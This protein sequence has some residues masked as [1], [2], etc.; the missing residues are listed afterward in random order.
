MFFLTAF[1]CA[2]LFH[3]TAKWTHRHLKKW[4]EK[5]DNVYLKRILLVLAKEKITLTVLYLVFAFILIF[6]VRDIGPALTSDLLGLLQGLS[7]KFSVDL[8][9][10]DLQNTLSQWQSLSY[11]FGDF[12]NVISPDTDTNTLLSQLFH[13]GSIFFQ[14]I[15]AYIIS[16]IWLLEYEKVQGYFAQLKEGPFAFFYNDLRVIFEKIQKSFGLVFQAQSK[17]AVV[18][19]IL[20]VTG[21]FII[22]LFY[23]QLSLNGT[24]IFP[25][26]LALGCITFLTSF[27]PFL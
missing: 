17:I 1:L 9:I 12:I 10:G 8:G 23:G 25:Y 15:F 5:T 21:L 2:Y 24:I 27:V 7:Q 16:Y 18:N 20:T 4:S 13:I 3:E 22:G 19:T 6:V 14:V 26:L 11:Q